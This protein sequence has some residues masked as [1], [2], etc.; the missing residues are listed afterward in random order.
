MLRFRERRQPPAVPVPPPAPEPVAVPE[1]LMVADDPPPLRAT[2][3]AAHPTQSQIVP[4]PGDGQWTHALAQLQLL[5]D[6][7]ALSPSL[8]RRWLTPARDVLADGDAV[9]LY[10]ELDPASD[11]ITVELWDDH[12]Q[13]LFGLDDYLP[14][15][16][17]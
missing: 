15:A 3:Y 10:V 6:E 1:Q 14:L 4:L 8:A 17:S 5:C 12:G 13:R 7:W 16:V 9:E 11:L 2:S